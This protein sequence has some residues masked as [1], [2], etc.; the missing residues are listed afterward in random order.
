MAAK[1]VRDRKAW[2]VLVYMVADDPQGGELLDQQAN[3]ELDRIVYSTLGTDPDNLYVA[4]Q[5]DYRSQRDVWRRVIGEGSWRHPETGAAN[6]E[7]LYGFFRWAKYMCPADRYVVMFWGHSRSLFGLFMDPDPWTYVAQTLTLTELR[8]A[9]KDATGCFGRELDIVVFKDCFMSTLEAASELKGLARYLVASQAI[10]PIEGWLYKKMFEAL[11]EHKDSPRRA[12][13]QLVQ[14]L[15][16]HYRDEKNRPGLPVVPF[17]V[18]D[19]EKAPVVN[20]ALAPIVSTLTDPNADRGMKQARKEV[21]ESAPAKPGD[22][23][24]LDVRALSRQ[25]KGIAGMS[26]LAS[27]FQHAVFGKGNN[28]NAATDD[29]LVVEHYPEGGK[30]GHLFG[31]V[32]LFHYPP[33]LSALKRSL[34]AGLASRK[35][36]DELQF[37]ESTWNKLALEAMPPTPATSTERHAPGQLPA[38]ARQLVP[39]AVLDQLQNQGLF[40]DLQREAY[41]L[42]R[43]TVAGIVDGGFIQLGQPKTLGFGEAKT[44]GFGEAKTLGFAE[45][46]TLGFIEAKTLGFGPVA[47]SAL[48]TSGPAVDRR[49][50]PRKR[51]PA[52][53]QLKTN[54]KS[55]KNGKHAKNGKHSK[56]YPFDVRHRRARPSGHEANARSA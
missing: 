39:L 29:A 31:G 13:V 47:A 46:K 12:A 36:Y 4:V 33:T 32:S 43:S 7:T 56:I 2:T 23:S 48:V 16:D 9:L 38:L 15:E 50:R 5:V 28:G 44:L 10:V 18:L 51:R 14:E 22:S 35:V 30:Y 45:A 3:R 24:L 17:A 40:E 37:R 41:E 52:I 6:P 25:W 27:G 34:V 54:G 1:Q 53:K 26:A 42:A 21:V 49:R 8:D 19:T 11:N 55:G 20:L